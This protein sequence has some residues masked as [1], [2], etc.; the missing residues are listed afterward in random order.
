[1]RQSGN[2]SVLSV[3]IDARKLGHGGI[4]VYLRNLVNGLLQA[5][6]AGSPL[7]LTLLTR[8]G[9]SSGLKGDFAEREVDVGLYSFRELTSLSKIVNEC[10][11]DIFPC[12]YYE[13][14]KITAERQNDGF[15]LTKFPR[16]TTLKCFVYEQSRNLLYETSH[17][18]S[19]KLF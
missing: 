10:G 11:A 6:D 4:G 12:P 19:R 9:E 1:M 15:R 16:K 18:I 7:E 13:L 17:S 3:L 5:R 14:S 2:S 8:K